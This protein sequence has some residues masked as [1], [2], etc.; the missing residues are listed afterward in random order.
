MFDKR[1]VTLLTGGL[2]VIILIALD[3]WLKF[4]SIANMQGQPDRTL[5]PGVVHLTYLEN[6]GA[7][8]GFLAGFGGAQILLAVFKIVVMAA[9]IMYYLILPYK[10]RF[11]FLRIPLMLIIAGGMGNLI[12]RVLHG[13]VVDMIAFSF[14]NF[15]VFNLADIYVTVG[16]FCFAAAVTFIVKDA[17]LFGMQGVGE[18]DED[19]QREE[20]M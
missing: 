15:P 18:P 12:D 19:L 17:P 7:A 2:D 11:L 8:F 20:D 5:I 13:F 4:W 14:F 6:T 16:V 10:T 9:A 1:W 3:Q